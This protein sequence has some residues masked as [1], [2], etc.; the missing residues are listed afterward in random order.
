M[1]ESGPSGEPY[2]V[3]RTFTKDKYRL[4]QE[5]EEHSPASKN[6][7]YITNDGRPNK[8]FGYG[9]EFLLQN[10]D[11]NLRI[12]A[13]G[14]A[15]SKAFLVAELIRKRIKGLHQQTVVDT[16][17]SIS[18]YEPL[19]EGLD[20]VSIAK[21]LSVIE[22]TLSFKVLDQNHYGY[23]APL[24]ESQVREIT[25]DDILKMKEP[26]GKRKDKR[27][28][29]ERGEEDEGNPARQGRGGFQNRVRRA[30]G[31]RFNRGS[32]RP[33][34][35]SETNYRRNSR[36]EYGPAESKQRR[37]GNHTRGG[38][39]GRGGQRRGGFQREGGDREKGERNERDKGEY[40][41]KDRGGWNERDRGERMERDKGNNYEKERERER[42]REGGYEEEREK[43]FIH[44][45]RGRGVWRSRGGGFRDQGYRDNE[46]K[47]F[48]KRGDRG[49][50]ERGRGRGFRGRHFESKDDL[51]KVK[52]KGWHKKGAIR[53]ISGVKPESG[54]SKPWFNKFE[55][56]EKK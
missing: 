42:E 5:K 56:E 48:V 6:E 2:F 3:E 43:K 52:K 19:E 22:I 21:K 27:D 25:L 15:I 41:E 35:L 26:K 9:A 45:G 24:N 53:K 10:Q 49:R 51:Y 23:Q 17:D 7:I 44:R 8:F 28:E 30:R 50:G 20:V 13:T 4:I 37:G 46:E 31:G 38:G 39:R 32:R 29:G 16:T 1:E 47:F 36:N 11:Q 54:E 14:K 12:K 55:G 34:S 33:R 40:Y 18:K